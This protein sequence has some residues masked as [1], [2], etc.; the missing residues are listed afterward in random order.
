LVF[1][2]RCYMGTCSTSSRCG[3][4]ST[5]CN[6]AYF[7]TYQRCPE[8][9]VETG[10][11]TPVSNSYH[12]G[13][14]KGSRSDGFF[15]KK[16]GLIFPDLG[17]F[18]NKE[19]LEDNMFIKKEYIN[20]PEDQSTAKAQ[21]VFSELV[22]KLQENGINTKIFH[23]AVKAADSIFPDWF[24]TA[25]NLTLPNGVLIISSM[26]TI[27]RRKE[28]DEDVIKELSRSYADVI[29]LSGF[30]KEGKFLETKGALVTDWKNGKIYCNISERAHEELFD[31]LIQELNRIAAK[32]GERRLRGIKFQGFDEEGNSIYHTDCMLAL[33]AKHAVL[34][35]DAIRDD[36]VRETVIKE[37]SDPKLNIHPKSIIKISHVESSNFCANIFN[38]LDENDNHCAVM[39]R[40]AKDNFAE[41]NLAIINRNYKV[42]VA[43]VDIVENI[44]GGSAR[45]MMVELF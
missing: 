10:S 20:M 23:Q 26:K 19:A 9:E 14:V 13:E 33:F 25:R 31:F 8:L 11:E 21:T 12:Y 3:K 45:C 24:T 40:R 7:F 15:A 18:V 16:V 1:F 27:E 42:L 43:N 37:I 39:S 41:D 6:T 44:G 22:T 29:D 34:C 32:T 5:I 30:E 17:F 35:A 28:K 38:L 36:Y 2:F 4:G